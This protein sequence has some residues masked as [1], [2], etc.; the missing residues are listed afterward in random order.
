[1]LTHMA[2]RAHAPV[3]ETEL[4]EAQYTGAKAALRPLYERILAEAV[5]LGD[6]VE[7]SPKKTSVSLRRNKQ[8]ALVTAA[9]NTRVDLGFNFRGHAATDRLKE[10]PP[11]RMCTHVV[12]ITSM[13]QVD[14]EV[15]GWL[16]EAYAGA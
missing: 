14:A 5:Q 11:G 12:R 9:T 16:R 4:V 7:V 15:L 2:G 13:E 10:E 6:D 8:F 1:M 3:G